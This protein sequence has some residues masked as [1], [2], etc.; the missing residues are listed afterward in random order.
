MTGLASNAFSCV[1]DV[2]SRP[3]HSRLADR[4][5]DELT[6]RWSKDE[7]LLAVDLA[8]R[9][10][11]I[12]WFAHRT[13]D[14]AVA[15]PVEVQTRALARAE[16]FFV[17]TRHGAALSAQLLEDLATASI[18]AR[19]FKG[20]LLAQA[21]YGDYLLRN[22]SDIDLIVPV[23]S[24][25]DTAVSLQSRGFKSAIALH[26]FRNDYFLRLQ[27]EASFSALGGA[28]TI[29]LHWKLVNRWNP[30]VICERELFDGE[31][32]TVTVLGKPL[33]W[34][35]AEKLFRIQLAHVISSD[36][37]GLKAWVD[38]AHCSDL[39]SADDWLTCAARCRVLGSERALMVALLVLE[40][41]F[42][43]RLPPGIEPTRLTQAR[44]IAD[45]VVAELGSG[46]SK[47]SFW[48]GISRSAT[49]GESRKKTFRALSQLWTPAIIDFENATTAKSIAS[50]TVD[51]ASR[52][53]R[54]IFAR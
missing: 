5:H 31:G 28:F 37:A 16:P 39:L 2:V 9:E 3:L 36:F 20:Q 18:S 46:Q 44:S 26:W 35:S 4:P 52:R 17:W 22:S 15:C 48:R 1:V 21:V 19:I 14:P 24:I 32:A 33:P 12:A 13:Q 8:A 54:Q 34:F 23:E 27:K 6:A 30:V 51:M 10:S 45:K 49:L 42:Q 50:L 7:W 25:A 29:D 38:L 11:L 40:A 41:V 53:L 47:L 43:R